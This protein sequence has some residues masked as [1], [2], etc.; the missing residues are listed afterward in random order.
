MDL[1]SVVSVCLFILFPGFLGVLLYRVLLF[2]FYLFYKC[3]PCVWDETLRLSLDCVRKLIV[4]IPSDQVLWT[5]GVELHTF[6][7][8]LKMFPLSLLCKP[9]I[10]SP[11]CSSH[12]ACHTFQLAG[13]RF[14][15]CGM[16]TS[17]RSAHVT[18]LS[19]FLHL[20]FSNFVALE[21][22]GHLLDSLTSTDLSKDL[23]HFAA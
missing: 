2:W 4:F 5:P 20:H 22:L 21:T 12:R 1:I 10:I 14:T 19:R 9:I 3:L 6:Q 11:A 15:G 8:V 17:Y 7:T 18:C 13:S 23:V 16:D